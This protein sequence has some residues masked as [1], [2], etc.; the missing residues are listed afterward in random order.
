VNNRL[1]NFLKGFGSIFDIYPSRSRFERGWDYMKNQRSDWKA[2]GDD[3]R[4]V[5]GEKQAKLHEPTH[6]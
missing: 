6:T 3:M 1:E 4:K 5:M 2:V